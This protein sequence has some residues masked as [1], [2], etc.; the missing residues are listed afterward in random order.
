DGFVKY[1]MHNANVDMD[2]EK[3]SKSLGNVRTIR[4]LLAN[5]PGEVL[6]LALLSAHYRSPLN[7]SESLL[8]QAR[9]TLDTFYTALRDARSAGAKDFGRKAS[10]IEEEPAY[11][12]LCDDLNTPLAISEMHALAKTMNK[13]SG[14]EQ[15]TATEIL[16]AVGE[17]LGVLQSDAEEWLQGSHGS[18]EGGLSNADIE[19]LL[20]AR[21]DA[22][23][24]KNYARADEIRDELSAAGV[25]LED[26]PSGTQWR[27]G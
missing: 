13:S 9:Q 23:A 16:L 1:W 12:A 10:A 11:L 17:L 25:V 4:D 19:A 3:M 26:G 5:Y 24:A 7:F 15:Q 6:R 27:R 20:S 2:G 22:K 18:G 8:E 21:S 14:E